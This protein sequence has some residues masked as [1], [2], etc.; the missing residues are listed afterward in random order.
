MKI[1]ST[2]Q[3]EDLL[4]DLDFPASKQEIVDHAER[5]GSGTGGEKA[6]AALPLGEYGNLDEVLRS[7]PLD[8]APDRSASERDRQRLHHRKP[9]LAEHMRETAP[10]PIEEELRDEPGDRWR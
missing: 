1:A 5:R 7:V 2:R 9:G 3:V 10:P 6:L 8:P 4:D